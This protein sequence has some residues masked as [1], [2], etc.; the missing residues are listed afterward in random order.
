MEDFGPVTVI[1]AGG[2]FQGRLTPDDT[3]V[4]DPDN[5]ILGPAPCIECG[6]PVVWRRDATLAMMPGTYVPHVMWCEC[7]CGCLSTSHLV[8][9]ERAARA[10]RE[11]GVDMT[12][13][14]ACL[15]GDHATQA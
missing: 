6:E 13:C 5:I 8:G 12:T 1:T 2:T 7:D 10:T 3:V 11:V 9:G 4:M 15:G 14:I